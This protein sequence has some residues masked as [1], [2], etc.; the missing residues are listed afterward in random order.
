MDFKDVKTVDDLLKTAVEFTTIQDYG[1]ET[2]S[3]YR[4]LEI[5]KDKIRK[6]SIYKDNPESLERIISEM[7]QMINAIPQHIT[8]LVNQA[9][10]EQSKIDERYSF[11]S[12]DEL[13]KNA[14]EKEEEEKG[15]EVKIKL[16][17]T[18][19][20]IAKGFKKI[21]EGLIDAGKDEVDEEVDKK[22]KEDDRKQ[23]D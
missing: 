7:D 22:D 23:K 3:V 15:P 14:K 11:K 13:I 5:L 1:P 16:K 9:H 4:I 17:G 18:P 2:I 12:L 8:A 20:E 6:I 19:E 21:T 10:D